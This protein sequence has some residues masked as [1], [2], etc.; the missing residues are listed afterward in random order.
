TPDGTPSP[1][2]GGLGRGWRPAPMARHAWHPPPNL[3]HK[4]GGALRCS[5][6]D[7]APP[8]MEHPPPCGEGWGGGGGRPD[9]AARVAP[10]SQPPPQGGRC[11]PWSGQDRAQPR[12]N[13]L[14][15]VGRAGEGVAR[16]PVPVASVGAAC[17]S[18]GRPTPR[19]PPAPPRD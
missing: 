10:P 5:G 8:P 7:R 15:L 16:D 1:L 6:E 3:P 14:P 2:W 11:L 19:A 17:T 12:W 4:G 13:T 9:G 18:S